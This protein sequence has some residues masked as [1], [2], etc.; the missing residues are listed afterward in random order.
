ME[1][2][3]STGHLF[4]ELARDESGTTAIEYAIIAAGV[5]VAIAATVFGLG[6]AIKTTFYD[7]LTTLF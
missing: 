4:C 2:L 7:K 5:S 6:E 1:Q 3:Q